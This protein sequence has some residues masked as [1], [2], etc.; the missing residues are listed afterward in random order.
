MASGTKIVFEFYN[1]AGGAMS[2]SYNYGD[3]DAT[4]AHVKA[5]MNTIITNKAIFKNQPT[6]IRGA[7]AVITTESEFDLSD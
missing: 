1:E 7:K 3:D 6:S 2:L 5:A 4:T